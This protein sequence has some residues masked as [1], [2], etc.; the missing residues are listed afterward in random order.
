MANL[1]AK[2]IQPFFSGNKVYVSAGNKSYLA[3][4]SEA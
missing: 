3:A 1:K 2:E 4:S